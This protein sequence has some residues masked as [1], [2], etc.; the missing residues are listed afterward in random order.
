LQWRRA[1]WPSPSASMSPRTK[2]RSRF[3]PAN[4][5][6]LVLLYG[7]NLVRFSRR[8][9]GA[10]Q[11][12]RPEE[13]GSNA[14]VFPLRQ[15]EPWDIKKGHDRS[16]SFT[17]TEVCILVVYSLHDLHDLECRSPARAAFRC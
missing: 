12:T 15:P 3:V 1:R 16:L 11:Q 4:V 2:T 10:A 17:T 6:F 5:C 14:D 8:P 9:C 13:L 7:T